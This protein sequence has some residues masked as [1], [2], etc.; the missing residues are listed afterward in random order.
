MKRLLI[1]LVLVLGLTVHCYAGWDSSKPAA[2]DQLNTSQGDIQGNFQALENTFGNTTLE[3]NY[4]ITAGD[5]LIGTGN[6]TLADFPAANP[7]VQIV[8]NMITA[9]ATGNTTMPWDDTI[10]QNDEGDEYI[11]VTI[12]PKSATNKLLIQAVAMVSPDGA[13]QTTMALFQDSTA[14]ALAAVSDYMGTADAPQIMSLNYYMAAGTTSSTTFKI[15]MGGHTTGNLTLNGVAEG[16][17]KFGGKACTSITIT[18]Y[19]S[20]S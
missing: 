19:Y 7:C 2:G 3:T 20:A 5:M 1:T 14:N 12:T 4:T 10:P 16:T 13:L 9:V 11:N 17:R 8:N 15:R 6:A 18:E